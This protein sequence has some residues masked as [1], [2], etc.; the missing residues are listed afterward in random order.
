MYNNAKGKRLNGYSSAFWLI[1]AKIS[2][3]TGFLAC[4][5]RK[6]SDKNPIHR[7]VINQWG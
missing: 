6:N 7:L 5:R 3:V 4:R 2:R 1:E